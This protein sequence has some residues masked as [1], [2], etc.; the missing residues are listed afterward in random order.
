VVVHLLGNSDDF[1]GRRGLRV[2]ENGWKKVGGTGRQRSTCIRRVAVGGKKTGSMVLSLVLTQVSV[3]FLALLLM[4]RI[5]MDFVPPHW[6]RFQS[7]S[8][9][10]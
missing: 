2:V 4:R 8:S 1:P 7:R 6:L 10:S 9:T 5:E 3:S